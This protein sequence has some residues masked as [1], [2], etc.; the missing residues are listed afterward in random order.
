MKYNSEYNDLLLKSFIRE[1]FYRYNKKSLFETRKEEV[2]DE[3]DEIG[4]FLEDLAEESLKLEESK[5][6]KSI[7]FLLEDNAP[8]VLGPDGLEMKS[9]DEYKKPEGFSAWAKNNKKRVFGALLVTFMSTLALQSMENNVPINQKTFDAAGLA[10]FVSSPEKSEFE[11]PDG[12]DFGAG[13]AKLQLA[14]KAGALCTG[15]TL[16]QISK[17]IKK[18]KEAIPEPVDPPKPP[19]DTTPDQ[20]GQLETEQ[21]VIEGI[22]GVSKELAKKVEKALKNASDGGAAAFQVDEDAKV[23]QQTFIKNKRLAKSNYENGEA[24]KKLGEKQLSEDYG[25]ESIEYAINDVSIKGMNEKQIKKVADSIGNAIEGY[26]HELVE[27]EYS[28][29]FEEDSKWGS[30][31]SGIDKLGDASDSSDSDTSSS[32]IDSSEGM[33]QLDALRALRGLI[34]DEV[35]NQLNNTLK[36]PSAEMEL[37]GKIKD[38]INQSNITLDKEI[39]DKLIASLSSNLNPN[40]ILYSHIWELE[41]KDE[42]DRHEVGQE[43]GKQLGSYGS[44]SKTASATGSK[45]SK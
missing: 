4:K 9:G 5:K 27:Q 24:L 13:G 36:N 38:K 34:V 33:K 15:K 10:K 32:E 16:E 42:E 14:K 17:A 20:R 43:A 37:N 8:L 2:I 23:N 45:Y 40:K 30:S 3:I 12:F 35:T 31:I 29:D 44:T 41:D 21:E 25:D 18:V 28:S 6:R 19:A 22:E 7:K 26:G 1:S 11:L 39:K